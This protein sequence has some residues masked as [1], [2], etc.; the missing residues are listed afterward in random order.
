ML[1]TGVNRHIRTFKDT[2]RRFYSVNKRGKEI[3]VYCGQLNI[4]RPY[5][6]IAA[7]RSKMAVYLMH[8]LPRMS[9]C[10]SL[11]MQ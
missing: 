4:F 3:T 8:G 9:E 2:L 6:P 10:L 1:R 11:G 7:V 5:A